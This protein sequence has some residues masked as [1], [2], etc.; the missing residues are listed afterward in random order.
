MI[1]K[2]LRAFLLVLVL[3]AV[4]G[5]QAPAGGGAVVAMGGAGCVAVACDRRIS[6]ALQGGQPLVGASARRVLRVHGRLLVGLSG[7]DGDVQTFAEDLTASVRLL[8]LEATEAQADPA[9]SAP[10][11]G[12]L[13]SSKLYAERTRSPLYVEPIIAG[14]VYNEAIEA[15]NQ[16]ACKAQSSAC[17][18]GGI[19]GNGNAA[20]DRPLVIRPRR[21]AFEP[22]LC[23]QDSLGAPMVTHDFVATG[24][25][26]AS[27]LGLCE[28]LWRYSY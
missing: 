12:R 11:L 28:A 9:I 8:R 16:D 15:P 17:S 6:S 4:S 3:G 26:S 7:L 23:S 14:L 13:I 10:A 25:C 19:A 27:L 22:Y 2:P 1:V 18:G 24:S 20:C 21:G 5:N